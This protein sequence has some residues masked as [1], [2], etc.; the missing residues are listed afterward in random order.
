MRFFFHHFYHSLAWTYDFVAAVVSIGRWKDWG[1]TVLPHLS[2]ER[3]LELGFGPGH[4]QVALTR[5][6]FKTIGLDESRQMCRQASANLRKNGFLPALSRGRAQN[7]PFASRSF[8]RVV[9][10]FPSEYIIDPDTLAEIRRVLVPGGRLVVALSALPGGG[11]LPDRAAAWLFR[12]TGQGETITEEI[13]AQIKAL[14]T[15]GRFEV[16]LI[17]TEVRQSTVLLVVAEK[18]PG[19]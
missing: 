14:F 17:R 10:T 13:E 11:N 15:A 5:A 3:I 2:G 6:G 9:A 12:I 1:R 4:L 7:L 18:V 19:V 16:S 8:D